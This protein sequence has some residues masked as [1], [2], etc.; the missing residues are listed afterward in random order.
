MHVPGDINPYAPP[1]SDME[2][3]A[4]APTMF[5]GFGVWNDNGQA[6]LFANGGRLPNR[7]VVCNQHAEHRVSKTF[8]WHNPWL[9]LLLL[10][11]WLF[12]LIAILVMRKSATVEYWLCDAH[13][14]RRTA[15]L[16]LAWAGFIVSLVLVFV[17]AAANAG[18][19]ALVCAGFMIVF[20]IVGGIMAQVTRP[21][22]ITDT[23][24]RLKVGAPFAASLPPSPQMGSI[25]YGAYGA[26]PLYTP[27]APPTW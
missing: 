6:A 5:A 18:V 8:Q 7:C 9:Y 19:V 25:G 4:P 15:G 1:R 16:A 11:G 14:K 26:A 10:G 20:P 22:R 13:R 21:T 3:T 23:E 27:P 12:Y 24:V 17:A 2:P